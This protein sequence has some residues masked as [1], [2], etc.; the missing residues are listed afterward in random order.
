MKSQA[1][2]VAKRSNSIAA[3][4]MSSSNNAHGVSSEYFTIAISG[5][6]GLVGKSLLDELK[7]RQYQIIRNWDLWIQLL[8]SRR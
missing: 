8:P 3:T 4:M 6:S 5:G 1:L 2:R 7:Q